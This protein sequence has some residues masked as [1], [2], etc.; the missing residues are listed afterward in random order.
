MKKNT[1]G[2]YYALA[3]CGMEMVVP[4]IGGILLDNWLD[5]SPIFT[6]ITIV[7]GFVGGITHMVL[8]SNQINDAERTERLASTLRKDPIELNEFGEAV[9]RHKTNKNLF[10]ERSYRWCDRVIVLDE[11]EGRLVIDDTKFSTFDFSD[12]I[13]VSLDE[14]RKVKQN[15]KDIYQ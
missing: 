8:I 13:P 3:T 10:V 9:W 12:W 15:F 6:A 4:M 11:T 2:L 14:F 7:L 5:T 1:T